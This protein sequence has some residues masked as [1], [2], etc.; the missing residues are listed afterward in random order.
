MI[1]LNKLFKTGSCQRKNKNYTL[2]PSILSGIPGSMR[3]LIQVNN[4]TSYYKEIH[5]KKLIAFRF[6]F[7]F[8]A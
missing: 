2:L 1:K 5:E 7:I 6:V 4:R 3:K 8:C